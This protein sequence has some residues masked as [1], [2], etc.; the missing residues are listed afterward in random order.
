MT[1]DQP[2]LQLAGRLGVIS[3]LRSLELQELYWQVHPT[4][5][6]FEPGRGIISAATDLNFSGTITPGAVHYG[7]WTNVRGVLEDGHE[8]FTF[9]ARYV[10]GFEIP[11]EV[12]VTEAE[13]NAFG[14]V[15][16]VAVVL[17]YVRQLVS[18]VTSRA[19]LPP[20]VLETIRIPLPGRPLPSDSLPGELMSGDDPLPSAQLG[21]TEA[22][23]SEPSE[24]LPRG[25]R[26][27][28]PS[29]Q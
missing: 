5:T 18:D 22:A 23:T 12:S 11:E 19:G 16:V 6:P 9:A 21:P 29:T 10:V 8:L 27:V 14:A 26:D 1:V 3:R 2:N 15:T 7:M 25:Q 13:V 4:A 28:A 24:E 20:L 17:P